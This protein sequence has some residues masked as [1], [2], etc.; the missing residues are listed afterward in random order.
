M[1]AETGRGLAAQ[2]ERIALSPFRVSTLVVGSSGGGKSTV[3]A[4]LVE[5]LRAAK[6]NFCIIDPEGD[7][8]SVE[9]AVVLGG[10]EHAPTIDECGVS[11]TRRVARRKSADYFLRAM[12]SAIRS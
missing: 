7:Y 5:R 6:Y 2:G 11:V 8:D 4:G 10:P 12:A 9:S 1:D 3:V